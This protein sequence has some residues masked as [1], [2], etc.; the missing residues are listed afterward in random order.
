MQL[1][2]IFSDFATSIFSFHF[3]KCGSWPSELLKYDW[4]LKA[5]WAKNNR[6]QICPCH[7]LKTAFQYTVQPWKSRL[8][9]TGLK[10]PIIES[11]DNYESSWLKI[12]ILLSQTQTNLNKLIEI[13]RCQYYAR[14]KAHFKIIGVNC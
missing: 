11:L 1:P 8:T 5:S 4:E 13:C 7:S 12:W 6:K 3:S 10:V 14:V 2:F 9:R